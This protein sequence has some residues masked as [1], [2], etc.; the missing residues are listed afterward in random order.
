MQIPTSKLDRPKV[1]V[2]GTAS[3]ECALIWAYQRVEELGKP[4]SEALGYQ[5]GEAVN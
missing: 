2:D 1:V 3:D 4:V 5:L